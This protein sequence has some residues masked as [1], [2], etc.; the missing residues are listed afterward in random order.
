M[1]KLDR[2]K[3]ELK[4]LKSVVVAFS[5][6]VD[7]SLLLKVASDVLPKDKTLAVTAASPTYTSSELK[8]AKR[9]ASSLGVKHRIIRTD[10]LKDEKFIKNPVDRCYYCKRE[11]FKKLTQIA[12]KDRF[13]SVIDATNYDDRADY[14][15]GSLAKKEFKVASPLAKARFTKKDIRD[16][17][18]KMRLKTWDMPSMACLASRF[19]YGQKITFKNLRKISLA[20]EAIKKLG[21][22]QVR[23][24]F[25]GDI[26]RIEIDKKDI[27][28]FVKDGFYDRIINRLK[29][30][31]FLYVVL[32]LEG[33]RTGS[34]N[35]VL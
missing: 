33:Y 24:R 13:S 5:G 21:I 7:S 2:L 4:K 27:K 8:Q 26:A 32:D 20:E 25:H 16:H 12:K 34:L 22:K 23:V 28:R 6:G 14:R 29:S 15:P 11:L 19:P 35:E 17:S 9:F 3:N 31:G 10:E 1:N 30:L 18:R